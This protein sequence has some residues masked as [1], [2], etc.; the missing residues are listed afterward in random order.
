[1]LIRKLA[2]ITC[3]P[4]TNARLPPNTRRTLLSKPICSKFGES[5]SALAYKE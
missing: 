5:M 1:M 3:T 2:N 4:L